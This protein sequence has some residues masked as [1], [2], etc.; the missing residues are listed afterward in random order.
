M[1]GRIRGYLRALEK[2][3]LEKYHDYQ[4]VYNRK[5]PREKYEKKWGRYPGRRCKKHVKYKK[6]ENG[7]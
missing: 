6:I 4:D 7:K 2:G 5:M 3:Q 1:S